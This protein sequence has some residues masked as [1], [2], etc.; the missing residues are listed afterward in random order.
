MTTGDKLRI[1]GDIFA[2][3]ILWAG[4]VF[5]ALAAGIGDCFDPGCGESTQKYVRLAPV[6]LALGFI[7]HIG[8]YIGRRMKKARRH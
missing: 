5:L 2:I 6:L 1:V 3:L 7:L 8:G 4:L